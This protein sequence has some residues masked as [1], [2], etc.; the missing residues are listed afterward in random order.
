M[1]GWGHQETRHIRR[2]WHRRI[3]WSWH[4]LPG[5]LDDTIPPNVEYDYSRVPLWGHYGNGFNVFGPYRRPIM[6]ATGGGQLYARQL[7][8]LHPNAIYPQRYVPVALTGDGAELH[9]TYASLP[10]VNVS[11][12][13]AQVVA[14]QTVNGQTNITLQN[15]TNQNG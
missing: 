5:H 3:N 15:T 9:G 2:P 6:G 8:P 4:R 12:P 7:P 11:Q 14:I 13:G 1:N 10:L